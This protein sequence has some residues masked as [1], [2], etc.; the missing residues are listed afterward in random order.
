M[1]RVAGNPCGSIPTYS[2]CGELPAYEPVEFTTT[3]IRMR[4]YQATGLAEWHHLQRLEQPLKHL[5]DLRGDVLKAGQDKYDTFV[6]LCRD[7][8]VGEPPHVKEIPDHRG[9]RFTV[10][11][12][13]GSETIDFFREGK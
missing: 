9:I 11:F 1:P 5:S 3:D 13:L 7:V 8:Y 12:R 10:S 2:I 4:T 6:R